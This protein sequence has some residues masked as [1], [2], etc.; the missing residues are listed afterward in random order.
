MA[1]VASLSDSFL[2]FRTKWSVFIKSILFY[3]ILF[4]LISLGLFVVTCVI[5]ESLP[6]GYSLN[7]SYIDP[8]VFTGSPGAARSVLSAIAAGWAT[9]LGVAF[10]VTLITMQLSVSK[11]IS[12]LVNRFEGDRINQLSIG[13]FIF[14]VTY[15]LLVLKTV[16]TGESSIN[17]A[18]M[19]NMSALTLGGNQAL[20]LAVFTP[21]VGVNVAIVLSIVALFTLVLYLHNISSYLK[22][23][24]LISKLIDQI[25]GALKPY[26]MRTPDLEPNGK[27]PHS[28]R[29]IF[30][31]NSG[32]SGIL[33]YVNWDNISKALVEYGAQN[34]KSVWLVCSKSIGDWIEKRDTVA[35]VYGYNNSFGPNTSMDGIQETTTDDVGDGEGKADDDIKEIKQRFLQNLQ[36]SSDRDLSRDPMFGLEILRSVAVKSASLGDTDVVM[37]CITGLFRILHYSLVHKDKIGVPFTI[38][39]DESKHKVSEISLQGD[40]DRSV[41]NNNLDARDKDN[42][43]KNRE[44]KQLPDLKAI[45][46]PKEVL[47]DS[48]ILIELSTIVDKIIHTRHI[49]IMRHMVTEYVSLSKNL[50]R[51]SK[52]SEFSM[53]TDWSS[54]QVLLAVKSFP[55]HL[56]VSFV[57]PLL[58]FKKELENRQPLFS[59]LFSMHMKDVLI[60]SERMGR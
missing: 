28:D 43:H 2:V 15:S 44:Q 5:D 3:P 1:F 27:R 57:D 48:A 13:W 53:L 19:Q 25:F 31:I 7:I 58:E 22:P 30:E 47:L 56:C 38:A 14:T 60:E 10:S 6:T 11:Y 52:D 51:D 18:T 17:M 49:P 37:S 50:V 23:N 34:Q 36:I 41:G 12:H 46:K 54:G 29:K 42:G 39:T 20:D 24:I 32:H 9:I 35:T 4:A 55:Q 40:Q 45:I 21:I 16:R 59:H 8:L 33:S 26:E